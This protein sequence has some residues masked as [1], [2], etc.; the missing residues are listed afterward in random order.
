MIDPDFDDPPAAAAGP[1]LVLGSG[2][3]RRL[4]LLSQIGL[5]PDLVEAPN[6]DETPKKAEKPRPYAARMALEKARVLEPHHVGNFIIT[7]DTVVATGSRIFPKAETLAQARECLERLS[8]RS[9]WVY[10]ALT[11]ISDTGQIFE[12]L[13]QNRVTFKRLSAAEVSSYLDSGEWQGKAGGYAIQGLAAGLI[14]RLQ[15]SF[16]AVVGLDLF[17]VQSILAGCGFG[18]LPET[19]DED[20]A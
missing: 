11:I 3:P 19:L 2:S 20:A 5:E 12:R 6:I 15:G 18:R 8:G 7:G 9:H 17:H 4:E 14:S 16:S 13:S 10:S 1:K